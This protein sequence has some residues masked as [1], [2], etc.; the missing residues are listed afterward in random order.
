MV[1]KIKVL[2]KHVLNIIYIWNIIICSRRFIHAETID[3]RVFEPVENN[4]V[5]FIMVL[6]VLVHCIGPLSK[7]KLDFERKKNNPVIQ[8]FILLPCHTLIITLPIGSCDNDS[9]YYWSPGLL[10]N[11]GASGHIQ[12]RNQLFTCGLIFFALNMMH[13]EHLQL[14]RSLML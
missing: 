8:V 3:P 1:V 11:L 14:G 12:P 4:S 6:M 2:F 9:T 7:Q 13:E 10:H 5:H